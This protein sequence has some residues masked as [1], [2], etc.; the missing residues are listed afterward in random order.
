MDASSSD[1]FYSNIN[2]NKKGVHLHIVAAN[3]K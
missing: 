3:N 1:L 2:E